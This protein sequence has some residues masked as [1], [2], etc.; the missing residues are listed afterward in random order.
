MSTLSF[1]SDGEY[2]IY[3]SDCRRNALFKVTDRD[4]KVND[5]LEKTLY[6]EYLVECLK[7]CLE[8]HNCLSFNYKAS[9]E[10]SQCELLSST[11]IKGG[12]LVEAAGWNHYEPAP[13]KVCFCCKIKAL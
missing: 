2:E 12:T 4:K 6:V 7:D 5:G 11:L 1:G 13:Q 10:N 8:N 9:K 3:K